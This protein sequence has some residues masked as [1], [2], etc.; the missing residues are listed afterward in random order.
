MTNSTVNKLLFK[1]G[2]VF[3][4]TATGWSSVLAAGLC[5]HAECMAPASRRAAPHCGET[6]PPA[7]GHSAAPATRDHQG[8]GEAAD[9]VHANGGSMH[10]TPRGHTASCAHCVG[11]PLSPAK[12]SPKIARSESRRDAGADSHIAGRG[13]VLPAVASFPALVPSQGSPPAPAGPRRHLVLST[14]LI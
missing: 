5:P 14:F 10:G 12:E 4:L 7:S 1:V 13:G 6:V 2:L 9:D 3:A 8:H 11:A